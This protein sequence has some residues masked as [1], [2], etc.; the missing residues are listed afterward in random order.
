LVYKNTRLNF[1]FWNN[2]ITFVGFRIKNDEQRK[3]L[4]KFV[5][6]NEGLKPLISVAILMLLTGF[7]IMLQYIVPEGRSDT[8][9]LSLRGN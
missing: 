1:L 9:R 4:S 2:K 6:S 8:K 5:T 7:S 3:V